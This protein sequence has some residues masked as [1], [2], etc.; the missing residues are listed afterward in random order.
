MYNKDEKII[1]W[2][3]IF[4]FLTYSKQEN[5]L[6]LFDSPSDIFEQFSSRKNDILKIISE[7]DFYK[8]QNALDEQFINSQILNLERQN[9]K[10]VTY[11]SEMYPQQFL[12]F[13][14]KPLILYCRGNLNLLNSK[15]I[16]IVGS[17]KV[18]RYGKQVTEKF[19]KAI[20]SSGL[21]V[22]SGLADGVDTISHRATLDVNGNTIA[23]M[24]SGF[25]HIYPK[26]N[27]SLEQEIEQKGLVITE[28]APN[29]DPAPWHYP[30][31]NRII[32]GLSD[33][34]LITEA[35]AKSGSLYTRD[36]CMEYGIDLYAIPGEIT[37][38]SSSGCNNIIKACQ[39]TMATSPDDIL[40]K[41][42]V[43]KTV[44]PVIKNLQLSFDEQAVLNAING[45]TH[46]DEIK[47]ATKLDTKDLITLLTMMELN[48]IIK[49]L[50][51][52]YY[53]K[54]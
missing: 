29:I 4:N 23:V 41:Y 19:A 38:F 22:V 30:I 13:H 10:V 2:L 25:N 35:S 15:C 51:G 28:Y 5:I 36:Y 34:V 24:G 1:I 54:Q 27:F 3:D 42:N 9:I 18:T 47:L 20:A 53:N 46:F 26:G 32:A 48:G 52:N 37:S 12:N 21:T 17:R 33:A 40:Q 39:A 44:Q 14:S 7:S 6:A 43:A 11:I 45:D 49:K 50:A 16:G 8:M 31:R